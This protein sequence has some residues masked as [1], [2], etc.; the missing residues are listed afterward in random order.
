MTVIDS[1]TSSFHWAQQN[2]A[3]IWLRTNWFLF[4]N[5]ALTDVLN[6]GLTMVSGGSWDQVINRYWALTR[7]SVFIGNTQEDKENIYA[8]NRGPVNPDT[9]DKLECQGGKP[10]RPTA[11]YKQCRTNRPH[12]ANKSAGKDEGIVIPIDNFSVYQRLYNIYDGPVYQESNALHA[13]QETARLPVATT[14]PTTKITPGTCRTRIFYIGGPTAFRE[15]PRKTPKGRCILPN[16]A[17]GWKQPNG[18]YY[19]PAFHSRNLFFDNVDIRHFMIVPL[20]KPGTIEVDVDCRQE[21]ILHL[22]R[23]KPGTLFSELSPISTARRNSTMTM[24]P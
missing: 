17:I 9:K 14:L 10:R 7:K 13:H 5:S 4:T 19:P 20:F 15:R 16:A 1:Y 23:R 3:A 12:A 11:A 21:D 22:S 18:F 8:Q 24:G 6:G 2:Y